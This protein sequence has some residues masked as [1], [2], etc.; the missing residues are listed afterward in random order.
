MSHC[1]K[2]LEGLTGPLGSPLIKMEKDTVL[3]HFIT[4]LTSFS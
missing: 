4:N 3:T 1:L 2:P